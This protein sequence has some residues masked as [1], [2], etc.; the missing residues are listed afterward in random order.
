MRLIE[1][2]SKEE[3]E[4]F[5]ESD[6][7]VAQLAKG[8]GS[9]IGDSCDNCD[10]EFEVIISGGCVNYYLCYEHFVELKNLLSL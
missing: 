7:P 4:K 6:D 10:K 5:L 9:S 8:E 2:D 1:F 3:L